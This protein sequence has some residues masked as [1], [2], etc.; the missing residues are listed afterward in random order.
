MRGILKKLDR[1]QNLNI[2]EYTMVMEYAEQLRSSSPESYALFY[3]KYALLLYKDYT[4]YIP[5]FSRGIDDFINFLMSHPQI[6][7]SIDKREL[8]LTLFP[9]DLQAYLQYTFSNSLDY[10]TLWSILEHFKQS[11][12]IISQ[13]PY[14]RQNKIVYKY[15]DSNPYKEVGL[16]THFDRIGRYSFVTR[17]QT[18]RYLSRNKAHNDKIEYISP[19]LLGGIFTNKQK[20]IYY[21][22]FLSEKNTIKAQN[23]CRLLNIALYG[24]LK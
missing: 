6:I 23:A 16:K 10:R 24:I 9:A 18:Y 19:D 21:Y 8:P 13:L 14:A 11:K 7:S 5:R 3:D 1:R 22:I 17:L 15:E 20:S 12:S 4:T 2:D